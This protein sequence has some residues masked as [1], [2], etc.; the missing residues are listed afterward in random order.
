MICGIDEVGRGT[1]AGILLSCAVVLGENF[2]YD[3]K[4]FDSKKINEK[5]REELN[6]IIRKN[7]LCFAFGIVSSYE[8]DRL[9]IHN[10]NLLAFKRAFENLQMNKTKIN[11]VLVDGKFLPPINTHSIEAI[12]KGDSK[13]K[14]IQAAS[15]LAKVKRDNIMKMLNKF[16]QYSV[17]NFAKHKGYPTKE[18]KLLIKKYGL[19]NI[20]R[21]SFKCS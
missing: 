20:H 19:S 14:E 8:I 4:L 2:T 17:Y 5:K 1:L 21:K 12:I 10:A 13:I 6:L 15:I 18:H 3:L 7:A 16:P 11:K 9:N